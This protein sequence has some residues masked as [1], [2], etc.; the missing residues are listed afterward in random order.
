[1]TLRPA[2]GARA[3]VGG[4]AASLN[5]ALLLGQPGVLS[6]EAVSVPPEISTDLAAAPAA[7]ENTGAHAG[8]PAAAAGLAAPLASTAGA[9][10]FSTAA[11]AAVAAAASAALAACACGVALWIRR[12]RA[13]GKDGGRGG[14]AALEKA[15]PC[16]EPGGRGYLDLI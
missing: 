7:N 11:A 5:V 3:Q 4:A 9:G 14:D 16:P 12:R 2:W 10:G 6:V 13:G 1:M 8:S 15:E